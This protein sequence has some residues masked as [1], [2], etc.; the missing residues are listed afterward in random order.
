MLKTESQTFL[1]SLGAESIEFVH[2]GNDLVTDG[3]FNPNAEFSWGWGSLGY[4]LVRWDLFNGK[5]RWQADAQVNQYHYDRLG[6]VV[7]IVTGKKYELAFTIS[8]VSFAGDGKIQV[9]LDYS[10]IYEFTTNGTY[11]FQNIISNTGDLK[12]KFRG[13][14]SSV[15]GDSDEIHIDNVSLREV[16]IRRT[17]SA[18]VNRR[19]PAGIGASHGN[20]P[21]L[22]ITVANDSTDGISSDE[23]NLGQ[24]LVSLPVRIGEAAQDRRIAKILGMDSGMMKLEVR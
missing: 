18:I 4:G 14:K 15:G 13:Y 5:A 17:I 6:Q 19:Q 12:V 24:N 23:I 7:N 8:D 16:D 2:Y 11:S 10:T 21:L 20:A 3:D 1:N 9:R 22:E